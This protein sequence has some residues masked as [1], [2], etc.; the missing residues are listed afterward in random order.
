MTNPEPL[1]SVIT[2]TF[3]RPEMLPHLYE[4]FA[5]QSIGNSELIVVDDSAQKSAFMETLADTRVRYIY[6]AERLSTGEKRNLA[7]D[8][9]KGEVIVQFDDDDYYAPQ[10]IATMLRCMQ[11]QQADFVKL[12]SFF[13]YS[14]IHRKYAYWE[15]EKKGGVHHVWDGS[16]AVV[17][18]TLDN[19]AEIADI[20]LGY[21]FSYIFKRKV[22][23]ASPFPHIF[24]NQDTPFIKAAISNG[25]KI[26]LVK[27]S[28]GICLHVLHGGNASKSFPQHVFPDG[29]PDGFLSGLDLAYLE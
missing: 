2:P 15:T 22:W 26:C 14:K 3:G 9:A 25:F 1:V 10:Y 11:Q 13:L 21:G 28:T 18:V 29:L 27:D 7:V 6:L 5:A 23:E 12:C 17:T 24:F 4:R 8:A 16:P 20:H 19:N